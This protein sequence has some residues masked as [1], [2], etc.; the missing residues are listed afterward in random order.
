MKEVLVDQRDEAD[1]QGNGAVSA[2]DVRVAAF[3]KYQ[4]VN[5]H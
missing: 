1:H 3:W 4:L 5:Y 2:H